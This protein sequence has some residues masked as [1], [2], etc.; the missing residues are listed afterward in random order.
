MEKV[1]FYGMLN[2]YFGKYPN[3]AVEL[4]NARAKGDAVA[5]AKEWFD[6]PE[7]Y[8]IEGLYD[9]FDDWESSATFQVLLDKYIS[10]IFDNEDEFAEK[11]LIDF[12]DYMEIYSVNF[13]SE[14]VRV[15]II[16]QAGNQ[17]ITSF[18]FDS[19]MEWIKLGSKK[20]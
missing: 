4:K 7:D 9:W 6:L 1:T 11:F 18:T 10:F 15:V 8:I 5:L 12:D 19:I 17:I 14:R 13:G 2:M 16:D 3:R 20:G